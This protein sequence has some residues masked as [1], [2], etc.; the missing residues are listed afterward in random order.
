LDVCDE[1]HTITSLSGFEG[2]IRGKEVY[3][4]GM[5][6]YAGWGL[7]IDEKKCERRKRKLSVN[8]LVAG[9]YILYPRYI[10]PKTGKFCEVEVLIK[11]IEE[12]KNKY[13]NDMIYRLLTDFRNN[14]FRKIQTA[15]KLLQDK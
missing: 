4:Y 13:N 11:D 2:I 6:F 7:T 10:S 15:G 9:A 1:V 14:I 12:L 5:P 8:E 3:T